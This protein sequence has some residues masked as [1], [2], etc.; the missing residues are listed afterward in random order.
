MA[1]PG[2]DEREIEQHVA[3]VR[4]AVGRWIDF[5]WSARPT[6]TGAANRDA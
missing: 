6:V 5:P 3:Q 2:A 4:Y 1:I